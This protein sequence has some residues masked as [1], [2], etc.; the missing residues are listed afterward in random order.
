MLTIPKMIINFDLKL[1]DIFKLNIFLMTIFNRFIIINKINDMA[2]KICIVSLMPIVKLF[3][4]K[5]ELIKEK[6]L[7]KLKEKFGL[8][9]DTINNNTV[10][11][12]ITEPVRK[13]HL[14]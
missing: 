4:L 13:K 3:S 2:E 10:N 7:K 14:I 12:K 1:S 5:I 11:E 8:I 9:F 6:Y